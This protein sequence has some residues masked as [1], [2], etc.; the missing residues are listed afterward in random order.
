MASLA[1]E[2]VDHK[3]WTFGTVALHT[4]IRPPR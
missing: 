2:S 4:G 1:Y 3:V